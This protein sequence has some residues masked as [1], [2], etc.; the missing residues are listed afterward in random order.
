MVTMINCFLVRA[1]CQTEPIH[2]LPDP[3]ES[4]TAQA[5]CC[6]AMECVWLVCPRCSLHGTWP[7]DGMIPFCADRNRR[8]T[9]ESNIR[10]AM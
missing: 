4:S 8:S 7:R 6:A 3:Q 5:R 9:A 2:D 1:H 10:A